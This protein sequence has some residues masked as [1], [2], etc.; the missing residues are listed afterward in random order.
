MKL[1]KRNIFDGK[2]TSKVDRPPAE[3]VAYGLQS[4]T[5]HTNSK[6]EKTV[7]PRSGKSSA[8]WKTRNVSVFAV[9]ESAKPAMT[10]STASVRATEVMAPDCIVMVTTALDIEATIREGVGRMIRGLARRSTT[11]I[12]CTTRNLISAG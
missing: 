10:A 1:G 3:V 7:K 4:L 8:R 12:M 5:T 6:D 2:K 11:H 9:D